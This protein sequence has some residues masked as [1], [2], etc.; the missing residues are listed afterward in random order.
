MLE[1]Y[2]GKC[3]LKVFIRLL[4]YI[5]NKN[6]H[7]P[8]LWKNMHALFLKHKATVRKN[9]YLFSHQSLTPRKQRKAVKMKHA[10]SSESR[11]VCT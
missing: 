11:K 6:R 1:S 4:S 3:F 2:L 7:T 8:I 10:K 9:I 5:L